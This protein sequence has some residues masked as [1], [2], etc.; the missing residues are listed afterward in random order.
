[1]ILVL[2]SPS[3]SRHPLVPVRRID[4]CRSFLLSQCTCNAATGVMTD[5]AMVDANG[6]ML[7]GAQINNCCTESGPF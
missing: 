1:M 4:Y 3:N 6:N 5:H 7:P 2:H